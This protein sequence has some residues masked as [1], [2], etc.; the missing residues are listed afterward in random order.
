M[1]F[2]AVTKRPAVS[3]YVRMSLHE[4]DL[5]IWHETIRLRFP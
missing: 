3:L 4:I 2:Q 1:A 5:C